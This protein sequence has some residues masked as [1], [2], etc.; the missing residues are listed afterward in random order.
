MNRVLLI[1]GIAVLS[2]SLL[3]QESPTTPKAKRV[4]IIQGPKVELA[5]EHLTI[6]SWTTNNPGGSPVHYGI[7]HYGTDQ[8]RLTETAKSPI[9]LNSDHA[10]TVFRVRLDDLRAGTTYY[11]RVDSMRL[12]ARATA[13]RAP[14]G[15][16]VPVSW[17]MAFGDG[18][19]NWSKETASAIAPTPLGGPS[20]SNIKSCFRGVLIVTMMAHLSKC[21][22]L[23]LT[24]RILLKKPWTPRPWSS[25]DSDQTHWRERGEQGPL[26][27]SRRPYSA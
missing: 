26:S 2:G 17:V 21:R 1:L 14:S 12:A 7:V 20:V 24:L 23:S 25:S 15:T 22:I 3:A 4:Q 10:S 16:S 6:I 9:R 13:S 11:Y 19:V 18:A 8:N 27:P 5:R